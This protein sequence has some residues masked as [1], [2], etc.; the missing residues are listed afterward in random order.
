MNNKHVNE[1][2][3]DEVNCTTYFCYFFEPLK[4]FNAL[5]IFRNSLLHV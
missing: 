2:F 1:T 4:Q 3:D 5:E